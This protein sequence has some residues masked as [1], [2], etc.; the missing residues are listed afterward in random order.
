MTVGPQRVVDVAG[1][2]N[3]RQWGYAHVVVAGDLI[4]V[5]GQAG[6]DEHGQIVSLD[7]EPQA[8]RTFEN[9]ERALSAV[10]AGVSDLVA[11]TSFITDWRFAP[12]LSEVRK[13][14]LGENLV[15]DALVGVE[16]LALPE[17]LIE[18]QSVA[19]RPRN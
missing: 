13:E 15:T 12:V 7:F 11:M 14:M 2:S 5:A 18:V 3:S 9:I 17:M 8:R 10:G 19:V 1:L 16:Q 6:Q 4:F